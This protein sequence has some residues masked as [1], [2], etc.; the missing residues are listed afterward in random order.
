MVLKKQLSDTETLLAKEQQKII[1]LKKE[2][3]SLTQNQKEYQKF[4]LSGPRNEF[5][6]QDEVAKLLEVD[7]NELQIKENISQGF[8]K[9][10]HLI[11]LCIP[12]GFSIV[13]S[14]VFRGTPVAIKKIFNPNITPDL[15]ADMSNEVDM[16][17][18]LRH[19]NIVLLMGICSKPQNLC[20]VTEYLPNGSLF[21]LLH[22]SK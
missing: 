16:L 5:G 20:I 21:N 15:L 18:R 3:A 6:L 10:F 12:G 22:M 4:Q 2:I 11:N 19:P 17:N 8:I 14:G 13:H 7:Y 1:E 9:N